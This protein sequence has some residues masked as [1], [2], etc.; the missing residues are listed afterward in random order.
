MSQHVYRFAPSSNGHLHLGHAL[1]AMIN[2][3]LARVTRG[4]FLLRIEDIDKARCRPEFEAAIFED[5]AWLGLEWEEPV[6]RQSEHLDDY[7]AALDR[8]SAQG[9][10]YA[11]DRKSTRLNSSH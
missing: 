5:L 3:D 9:L 8:L 7:R 6:W 4:R 11:R 10:V 2:F 1:S